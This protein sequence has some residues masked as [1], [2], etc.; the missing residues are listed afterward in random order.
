MHC[1]I[2]KNSICG[3][4][5]YVLYAGKQVVGSYQRLASSPTFSFRFVYFVLS[6]VK[7]EPV[8]LQSWLRLQWVL[9]GCLGAL[10]Q[11]VSRLPLTYE[12]NIQSQGSRW[13]TGWHWKRPFFFWGLQLCPSFYHPTN[14][15][16][17]YLIRQSRTLHDLG[18]W[19]NR[20]L[21]HIFTQDTCCSVSVKRSQ[22]F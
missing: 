9:W 5:S 12:C 18:A 7:R 10:A 3:C 13:R 2:F 16:C 4:I 19:Q 20:Q 1:V 17:L 14:P 11:A 22:L 8:L 15:P 21:K 6:H